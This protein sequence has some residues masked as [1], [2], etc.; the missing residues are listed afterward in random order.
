MPVEQGS[1]FDLQA[2]MQLRESVSQGASELDMSLAELDLRAATL[3]SLGAHQLV[4]LG[5]FPTEKVH[6]SGQ[7]PLLRVGEPPMPD[8]GAVAWGDFVS[9]TESLCTV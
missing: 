9:R 5:I 6:F 7:A 1:H 4:A 8:N 3:I 2:A